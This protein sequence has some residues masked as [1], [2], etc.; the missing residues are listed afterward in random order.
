MRIK[1][2]D[3]CNVKTGADTSNPR[4]KVEITI[5][6]FRANLDPDSAERLA[7][8]LLEAVAKARELA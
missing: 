8:A 6:E 7:K 5:P 2:N 3:Y 4:S 1:V